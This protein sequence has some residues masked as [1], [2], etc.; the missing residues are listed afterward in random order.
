MLSLASVISLNYCDVVMYVAITVVRQITCNCSTSIKLF[1]SSAQLLMRGNKIIIQ[2]CVCLFKVDVWLIKEP[3]QI[4]L[5]VHRHPGCCSKKKFCLFSVKRLHREVVWSD[6]ISFSGC[7]WTL[8]K[9]PSIKY[10]GK[11]KC[12]GYFYQ[13]E[14]IDRLKWKRNFLSDSVQPCAVVK[15]RKEIV[16]ISNWSIL[17]GCSIW[18]GDLSAKTFR[19]YFSL[20]CWHFCNFYSLSIS[21][22]K[23]IFHRS[24][25]STLKDKLWLI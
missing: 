4:L 13:K 21:C 2:I 15:R 7:W 8:M 20:M 3:S 14:T 1:L 22:F 17:L 23:E 25:A 6:W 11:W 10:A 9:L 24:D 18:S 5:P 19:T 12:R 16:S